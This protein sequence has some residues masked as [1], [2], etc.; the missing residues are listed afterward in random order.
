[1]SVI[2]TNTLQEFYFID[3]NPSGTPVVFLHGL[4]SNSRAWSLQLPDFMDAGF[5]VLAP[6]FPGFGCS[7][8]PNGHAG[9]PQFSQR[10]SQ[11]FQE[12]GLESAAIVGLSLG[13][14]VALQFALDYPELVTKL[15]LVSAFARFEPSR[16]GTWLYMLRRFLTFEISGLQAQS[17]TVA[18]YI[19]PD[20]GDELL[21]I[22]LRRQIA[23]SDPST[24]RALMRS[25]ARFNVLHRLQEIDVPVLVVS[26]A[27]DRTVPLIAQTRLTAG[28]KKARHVVIP[29]A[30]HAASCAN[31]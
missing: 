14:V 3:N 17:D 29:N 30:G 8:A 27:L 15:V 10:L 9:I 6:D 18:R 28:I 7:A 4:G 22:E 23:V 13:G 21:R 25:L 16:A 12:I 2:D 24:Y 26:G 11:W 20:P 31:A 5:R 1:M 19:F